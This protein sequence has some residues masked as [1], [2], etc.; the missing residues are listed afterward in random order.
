MRSRRRSQNVGKRFRSNGRS[1]T[2]RPTGRSQHAPRRVWRCGGSR[3]ECVRGDTGCFTGSFPRGP[4]VFDRIAPR[5]KKPG[6]N[7]SRLT[8]EHAGVLELSP[9]HVVQLG[10]KAGTCGPCHSSSR[11]ALPARS[12]WCFLAGQNLENRRPRGFTKH[13]V[14]E[15]TPLIVAGG[16]FP[17][18]AREI[19]C[20]LATPN[21][22]PAFPSQKRGC[23]RTLKRFGDRL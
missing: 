2:L 12:R 14:P 8:F 5:W 4:K 3:E 20:R 1:L 6:D 7:L 19:P 23:E 22:K 13:S 10:R 11:R 18:V 16:T 9:Q 17:D 15:A 21:L